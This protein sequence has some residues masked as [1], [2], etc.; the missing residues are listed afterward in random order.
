MRELVNPYSLLQ[1]LCGRTWEAKAGI[2]MP[3][4]LDCMCSL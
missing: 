3:W 4:P 2:A 1:G